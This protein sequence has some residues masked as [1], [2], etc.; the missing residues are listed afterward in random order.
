MN[1][2]AWQDSQSPKPMLSHLLGVG[3]VRIRD[4]TAFPH[5]RASTRKFRLFA[6]AC[7]RRVS[8]LL[9]SELAD[10]TVAIAERFADGRATRSEMKAAFDLITES[11]LSQETKWRTARGW[12]RAHLIPAHAALQLA[13]QVVAP[14]AEHAAYYASSNAYLAYAELAN[15]G[16]APHDVAVSRS[17]REE[18]AAQAE[19]LRCIFGN[20]FAEE[21]VNGGSAVTAIA[22][23]IYDEEEFDNLP[24]FAD[25]L[26]AAGCT[27]AAAMR[28]CCHGTIHFRGCWVLDQILGQEA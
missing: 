8:P 27:A 5:C 7:Y 18:E 16:V 9:K 24:N 6:C 25:A 13:L 23:Q 20:L 1:Y 4:I 19:I 17:R 28:H 10:Q 15:P 12:E 22:Q 3:E 14:I 2:Q 21:G 11:L 26:E